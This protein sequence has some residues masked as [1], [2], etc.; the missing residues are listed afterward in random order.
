M[1]AERTYLDY[2]ATAPLRP[3]ARAAVLGA[4]DLTGNPSSTHEEG[5][6][7]RKIVDDARANIASL[8]GASASEIVFT[9][10]GTEAAN[11]VLRAP[12]D[13]IVFSGLEHPAVLKPIEANDAETV[14]IPVTKDG[15]FDVEAWRQVAS[16]RFPLSEATDDDGVGS[17]KPE[18]GLKA[19]LVLQFANNETGVIQP[20]QEAVTIAR[21][22]GICVFCDA[23][24]AVGK[25][26]IDVAA[27]DVDY[28]IL[29]GHKLGAPKGVGALIARGRSQTTPLILGGGQEK[30]RRGGTENVAGIAGLAA[31][32]EGAT[33]DLA[34][35]GKLSALR[36][37]LEQELSALTPGL[38]VAGCDAPRLPNTTTVCPPGR[39]AETLVIAFD[40]AGCA[41]SAGSACSSGKTN[42][43]QA[44]DAMGLPEAVSAAALRVSLGWET[45]PDDIDRFLDAW[46]EAVVRPASGRNVA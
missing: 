1:S 17:A 26:P 7:A 14:E 3:E 37:R 31:A 28:L 15:L 24:Q 44:L 27:L 13:I 8:I 19:L 4:L 18:H 21:A 16:D 39:R 6:N 43:S 2:N 29:S 38:V 22:H 5:R 9:S 10:G 30:S 41:V 35:F 32:L 36:D 46:R 20:L 11:M 45:Q 25:V 40:L 23:V 12:W 34:R 33:R 42:R